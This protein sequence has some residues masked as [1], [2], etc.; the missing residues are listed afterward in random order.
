MAVIEAKTIRAFT[1][2]SQRDVSTDLQYPRRLGSL[3]KAGSALAAANVF[4][5]AVV[6]RPYMSQVSAD[7]AVLIDRRSHYQ[8]L[9]V[10]YDGPL[11]S[12]QAYG[13]QNG[14]YLPTDL[15]ATSD[16]PRHY[17]NYIEDGVDWFPPIERTPAPHPVVEKLFSR[18]DATR[19]YG[20][21]SEPA[22]VLG[23]RDVGSRDTRKE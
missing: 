10:G 5:R 22:L 3:L 17:R 16:E 13:F 21:S 20:R 6:L 2:R 4:S 15:E 8:V 7:Y 19:D 14:Q 9:V 12:G 18:F 23:G 1:T 11:R